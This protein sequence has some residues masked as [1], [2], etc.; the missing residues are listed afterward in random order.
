MSVHWLGEQKFALQV[1]P[2]TSLLLIWHLRKLRQSKDNDLPVFLFFLICQ[3]FKLQ[4]VAELMQ[5]RKPHLNPAAHR[6]WLIRVVLCKDPSCGAQT[7]CLNLLVLSGKGFSIQVLSWFNPLLK[8]SCETKF[9]IYG[10]PV[11]P[12]CWSFSAESGSSA[13]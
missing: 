5:S 3:Y 9:L 1:G 8:S 10:R 12:P 4:R 7:C 11:Q 2:G 6:R 13:I